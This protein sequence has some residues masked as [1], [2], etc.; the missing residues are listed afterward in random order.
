[1]TRQFFRFAV[2][3]TIGFVIDAGVLLYVLS[4]DFDFYSAR[5]ISFLCAVTCTWLL[6]RVFTFRDRNEDLVGQW[7]RFASV[8]LIGGLINYGIYAVLVWQLAIVQTWPML[9]V[10][11]GS[12]AGMFINFALSRRYV[13]EHSD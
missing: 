2:V 9:G 5:A 12:I 7:V 1:M 3:G 13:F 4:L 11:A 10:A 8:N 6:N